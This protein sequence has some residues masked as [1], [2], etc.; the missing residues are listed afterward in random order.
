MGFWLNQTYFRIEREDL[1]FFSCYSIINQDMKNFNTFFAHI[2]IVI[3]EKE[4]FYFVF[5]G[6]LY[7]TPF[8]FFNY[9]VKCAHLL[10]RSHYSLTVFRE[11]AKSVL[12]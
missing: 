5:P 3:D 6:L 7:N 2:R 9:I 11:Y 4:N 1:K 10:W 8:N 12:S